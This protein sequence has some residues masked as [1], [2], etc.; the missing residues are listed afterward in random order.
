MKTKAV[1]Q[2]TGLTRKA[3]LLYEEKG[4]LVPEKRWSNGRE[5]REYSEENLQELRQIATLRKAWFTIDEIRRMKDNPEETPGIFQSYYQ[6]LLAQKEELDELLLAAED[7]RKTGVDCFEELVQ[8]LEQ[9]VKNLPLPPSDIHPRFRYL[10]E[11]EER[12]P[13]VQVQT[14]LAEDG[15]N[16]GYWH[17]AMERKGGIRPV[18]YDDMFRGIGFDDYKREMENGTV[19]SKVERDPKW[20]RTVKGIFMGIAGISG[21]MILLNWFGSPKMQIDNGDYW[22]WIWTW[23]CLFSGLIRAL[24]E[25]CT[26]LHQNRKWQALEQAKPRS[27]LKD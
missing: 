16:A 19:A 23:I 10:D 2:A 7:L 6:W 24:L 8:R 22:P 27:S 21:F 20:M 11:M 17:L 9:P 12:P 18:S 15:G 25:L 5:Y 26:W 4:L 1:C 3:L 14:N 13:Y